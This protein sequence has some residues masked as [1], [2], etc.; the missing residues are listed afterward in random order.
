M[1]FMMQVG[2]NQMKDQAKALLPSEMKD[3]EDKEEK[4]DSKISQSNVPKKPKKQS[5]ITRSLAIKMYSFLLFHTLL[6]TILVFLLFK[7]GSNTNNTSTNTASIALSSN[8]FSNGSN[9]T[10]NSSGTDNKTEP[11][12]SP[13]S[14]DSNSST[15]SK[16]FLFIVFAAC[17]GGSV[18]LSLSISKIQIL[19]KIYLNYVLYL[20]LLAANAIGFVCCANISKPLYE[21]VTSMFIIFDAGSVTIIIF[22]VLVKETPSTFWLMCSCSGGIFIALIIMLKIYSGSLFRFLVLLFGLLACGIYESMN[23][24]ALD[25]YN[26]NVKSEPT[27]PSMIS[28]PFELNVSFVKIFWYMIKGIFSLFSM[29]CP[30]KKKKK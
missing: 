11:P 6:I 9:S 15:S 25:S 5:P 19:S 2:M 7:G 30:N 29:C 21:L 27:A 22:S 23:Y 12:V 10:D 18:F 20:V 3:K 8:S 13:E 16:W 26:Q 4:G 17:L 24:N 14:S 1:N 28:L